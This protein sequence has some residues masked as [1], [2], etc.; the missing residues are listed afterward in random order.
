ML[1][2]A[3]VRRDKRRAMTH[4]EKSLFSID[5]LNMYGLSELSSNQPETSSRNTEGAKGLKLL[6]YFTFKLRF[7]CVPRSEN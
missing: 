7:F 5:K 3:D 1:I 6:R 2:V 4:E